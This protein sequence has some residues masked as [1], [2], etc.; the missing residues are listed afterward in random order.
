M[1]VGER[2][3]MMSSS[4]PPA[5]V[6]IQSTCSARNKEHEQGMRLCNSNKKKKANS[7]HLVLHQV[8]NRFSKP[9][10]NHV[11]CVAEEY[12]ASCVGSYHWITPITRLVLGN[13]FIR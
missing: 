11:G 2:H 4:T 10:R 7:N 8:S 6:T 5:L 1:Y 9:R 12:F 13:R 3:L